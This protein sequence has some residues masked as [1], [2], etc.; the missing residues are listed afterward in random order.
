MKVEGSE[1]NRVLGAP[2]RP[3]ENMRKGRKL[4]FASSVTGY[5]EG[6]ASLA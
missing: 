6:A 2:L 5:P 4:S 1:S 3:E